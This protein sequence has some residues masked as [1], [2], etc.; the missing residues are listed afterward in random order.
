MFY[1]Q[2]ILCVYLCAHGWEGCQNFGSMS[3]NQCILLKKKKKKKAKNYWSRI[4]GKIKKVKKSTSEQQQKGYF[5]IA[6]TDS[7][8]MRGS[9][10]LFWYGDSTEDPE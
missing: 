6:V 10:V 7:Y 4:R 2:Q 3:K 1:L 9:G 8:Q 5:I